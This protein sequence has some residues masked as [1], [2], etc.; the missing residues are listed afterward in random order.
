MFACYQK[1]LIPFLESIGNFLGNK[2]GNNVPNWIALTIT[3]SI[4]RIKKLVC[5]G[6]FGRLIGIKKSGTNAN[7][8]DEHPFFSFLVSF[9]SIQNLHTAK[10]QIRIKKLHQLKKK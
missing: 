1:N 7:Q 2:F 10:I 4:E 9:L 8:E 5:H 3:P 6:V